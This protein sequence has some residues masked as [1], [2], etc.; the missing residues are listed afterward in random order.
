[1]KPT[2]VVNADDLGVSRGAT[3]GI[4]RAHK[5]GIVTSA[6]ISPTGADYHNA[7][8]M[9]ERDCP[10][11]GV[12]LHFT[13]SAGS[14][15]S[16]ALEVPLLI[17]DSGLFRW[18]FLS[19]LKAVAMKKEN[20]LLDQIEIELESQLQRLKSDGIQPDHIDSERHVHLIPGLFEKVVRA[21][22]RHGIPFVR[23]AGDFSINL[24]R[25]NHF[26]PVFL[27]A[28]ILKYLLLESL[29]RRSLSAVSD[30]EKTAV[31]F[32]DQFAS[33]LFTG[34]LDLVLNQILEQA[35]P[36]VTEIMVHPGIPGESQGVNLGNPGLEEY[37]TRGDRQL[38]LQ[39]CIDASEYANRIDLC[40]FRTLA[41]RPGTA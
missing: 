20:G 19:L 2:I 24:V 23:A 26:K 11:L 17:D 40:S 38:E 14:P 15:V 36:G 18:E 41:D 31:R 3:L 9:V 39:A 4:V 7:L 28:G 1:M 35:P 5:E 10:D 33:Y 22:R 12:G 13:L 27:K 32:C 30:Q 34:R 25:A 8:E 37:L 16:S 21:A 6:S 29:R